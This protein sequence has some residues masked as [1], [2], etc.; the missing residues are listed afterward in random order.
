VEKHRLMPDAE[1]ASVRAAPGTGA[2][3]A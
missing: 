1:M 2:R 3:P